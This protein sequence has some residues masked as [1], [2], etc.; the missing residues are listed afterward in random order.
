MAEPIPQRDARIIQ[1]AASFPCLQRAPGVAGGLWDAV[2]L[3]RWATS[4][5]SSGER[6]SARFVLG[7]WNSYDEWRSGKFDLF[8]AMDVWDHENRQ[9]FQR[10]VA[11]PW[12]A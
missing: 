1:L 12:F 7:V 2:A 4:D 5:A 6:H 11:D 8:D 10:W 9:A 3:D